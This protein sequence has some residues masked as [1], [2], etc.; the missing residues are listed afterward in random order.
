MRECALKLL[1]MALAAGRS[2]ARALDGDWRK[3]KGVAPAEGLHKV[4]ARGPY[5]WWRRIGK[6]RT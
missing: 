2:V 4:L 3:V 5:R 6:R 1:P